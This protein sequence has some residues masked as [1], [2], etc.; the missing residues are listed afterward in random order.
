M[1]LSQNESYIPND[2]SWIIIT[3]SISLLQADAYHI[4]FSQHSRYSKTPLTK[5]L[6]DSDDIE[7]TDLTRLIP[8]LLKSHSP[9]I[10]HL[11]MNCLCFRF[12]SLTP[13]FGLFSVV[14]L[15]LCVNLAMLWWPAVQSSTSLDVAMK[16]FCRCD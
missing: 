1:V 4:F 13:K 14:R 10:L 7:D 2:Y 11:V 5:C 6:L 3:A 15:I 16:V 12:I 8:F 9:F